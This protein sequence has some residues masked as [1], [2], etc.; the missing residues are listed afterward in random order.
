MPVAI[1]ADVPTSVA[2]APIIERFTTF[3]DSCPI[4]VDNH[5]HSSRDLD[6]LLMPLVV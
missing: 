4:S 3:R 5:W 6:S 1:K 2:D